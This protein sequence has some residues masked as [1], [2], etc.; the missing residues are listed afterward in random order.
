MRAGNRIDRGVDMKRSADTLSPTQRGTG[1]WAWPVG[2]FVA[3]LL[4][5]AVWR[6]QVASSLPL[7]VD[8]AYYMA[9][10]KSLD[11][12][13]W[14]KPPLIA[15][16]IAAARE[17]FGE[18]PAAVRSMAL[19]AF[20]YTS[21][22]LVLLAHRMSGSIPAACTAA[23]L[24]ATLPLSAFYGV[25]ATTDALLLACWASAMLCL[26]L[27]LE[28][29][30]WAWPLLG[31]A[32]GLG[33]LAKYNMLIFGASA[34]L[35]MLHPAWRYHWKTAGPYWALGLALCVF[36]PNLV[37]N[38]THQMPTFAHTAEY[39]NVPVFALRWDSLAKFLAEQ[40]L[41]G[42]PVLVGACLLALP[43]FLRKPERGSWFLW[44]TAVPIL[45]VIAAQAL[46]AR[47]NA[48]WAAPAYLGLSLLG[49]AYLWE[50]RRHRWLVFA[51]ALNLTFAAGL[52]HFQTL[53][54][55][56]LGL[57]VGFQSDPYWTLRNWPPFVK[58]VE[59]LLAAKTER[60]QWRVASEDRG[61]LAQVQAVLNLPPTSALGW[62]SLG[63]PN[64]HFDQH[65]PL[66]EN[67]QQPVLLITGAPAAKVQR[68]F[69]QAV[70]VKEIR[71]EQMPQ[72]ALVY[73]A[74]WLGPR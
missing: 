11:F 8:E 29:K 55:K 25:A 21:T 44:A 68:A 72:G 24:F 30:K 10:S 56:P 48:N 73:Q 5:L 62:A 13:Y 18:T 36:S 51:L 31:L 16:A 41:I 74:W 58:E 57:Q 61:V 15:W 27:A 40:M 42:N 28:G 43:S 71:S 60:A 7:S 1:P 70:F 23:V 67:P 12:G 20:A 32:F 66:P 49:A 52:Y 35:I 59:G 63:Y 14:T 65:F 39:S 50:R 2:L 37:W 4:L 38:L 34:L 64:N 46:L 69:P 33:L 17:L 9:W 26:W 22:V 3:S 45:G 6:Y 19:L 47:A 53:L 54:A